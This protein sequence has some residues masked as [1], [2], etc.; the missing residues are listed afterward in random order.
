MNLKLDNKTAFVS[1]STAGIG[2]AI[3]LELAREGA[4]VFVN[5]RTEKRVWDAARRIRDEVFEAEIDGIAEDLAGVA[6]SESLL[7]RLPA[8]D[9]LVNNL[10]IFQAKLFE[11]ISDAEG[12]R[13]FEI[14]V[15]S[16]VRLSR[17][18]LPGMKQRNWGRI[19]FISSES[20][21]HIPRWF[22]TG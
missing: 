7:R 17:A 2:F 13:L 5:G 18:Y 4:R 21:L 6:G 9:I 14:N 22:T 15:M 10:G 16:G 12:Q 3:A 19:V 1:A 11:K 8:V 20:A